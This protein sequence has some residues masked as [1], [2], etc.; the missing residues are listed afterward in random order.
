M[1]KAEK[2][3]KSGRG[4][5]SGKITL[6]DL[7]EGL[8]QYRDRYGDCPVVGIVE[9]LGEYQGMVNPYAVYV[10]KNQD[11]CARI[12]VRSTSGSGTPV[13]EHEP[14]KKVR[15]KQPSQLS[16]FGIQEAMA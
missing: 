12:Y 9:T 4:F 16:L 3:G 13:P 6:N 14:I 15:K 8:E 10:R 7:L 2:A 1:K 11:E 5:A